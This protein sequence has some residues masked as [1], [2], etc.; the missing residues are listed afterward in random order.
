MKIKV[1][2]CGDRDWDD[3]SDDY[4]IKKFIESLPKNTIL[5]E[6]EARGADKTSRKCAEK[7]GFSD[8]QILRFPANWNCYGKAAGIM[9]NAEQL[10]KGKPTHVIAYHR[11]L[12]NSKGTKDMVK[13]SLVN[14]VPVFVNIDSWTD[15]ELGNG[16]IF[17]I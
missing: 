2:V 17:E 3:S 16:Q 13:R 1:L 9:R 4:I 15:I 11:N 10:A 12:V 6:G 7:C 8:E 5:I 14:G